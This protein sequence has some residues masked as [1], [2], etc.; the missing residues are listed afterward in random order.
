M[1]RKT[2]ITNFTPLR[3][4]NDR[5]ELVVMMDSGAETSLATQLGEISDFVKSL[6]PDAKV[7]R[8]D[9]EGKEVHAFWDAVAI[10]PA[11]LP[12][13]VTLDPSDFRYYQSHVKQTY[14][15]ASG[16]TLSTY[17]DR[18]T[19]RIWIQAFPLDFFDELFTD[20]ASAGPAPA[21]VEAMRARLIPIKVQEQVWTANDPNRE[22]FTETSLPV[23]CKSD[24]GLSGGAD[25]ISAI[26]H[27]KCKP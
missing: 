20:P 27:T 19:L 12:G 14:P 23:Y 10:D 5:L 7:K 22:F 11:A 2:N 16:T 25:K 17:P 13:P 8:E 18:V 24:R 3:G 9:S 1:A 4:T 6:P 15:R 21:E 26:K